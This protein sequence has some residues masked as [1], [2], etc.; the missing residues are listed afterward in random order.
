MIIVGVASRIGFC[1]GRASPIKTA[2]GKSG[3]G[4]SGDGWYCTQARHAGVKAAVHVRGCFCG[5]H[6]TDV[7]MAS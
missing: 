2:G 6:D 7:V 5:Q 3:K 1:A 4:V